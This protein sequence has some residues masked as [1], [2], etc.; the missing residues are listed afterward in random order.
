MVKFPT[1]GSFDRDV[2][3]LR[4]TQ[5]N[6]TITAK[7][8]A[9]ALLGAIRNPALNTL[10]APWG[11]DTLYPARR[12]SAPNTATGR[13]MDTVYAGGRVMDTI[14]AGGRV[15][16]TIYAG[17]RVMD[18]IYAGGRVMD[19]VYAGGRVMNTIYAGGRF[20]ET[21]YG[22]VASDAVRRKIG[23][24]YM[25]T[26]YGG[27]LDKP[28][29]GLDGSVMSTIY[30]GVAKDGVMGSNSSGVFGASTF[31]SARIVTAT[32]IDPTTRG[33]ISV[34]FDRHTNSYLDR[35]L[36]RWIS[37]PGWMRNQIR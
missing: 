29:Q 4:K 37:A 6:V 19:T 2:R 14:Y 13:I 32:V 10:T 21:I 28:K 30:G 23:G 9:E 12:G 7:T 36:S 25:D 26:V 35:K 8:S 27:G 22:G 3:K 1:K 24:W 16:D 15:M 33:A 17:G 31:A 20:T 34:T 18:T 11:N 5:R